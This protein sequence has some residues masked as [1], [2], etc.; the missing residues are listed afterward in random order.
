MT[1]EATAGR[2]TAVPRG[3]A[4]DLAAAGPRT[5]A[6]HLAAAVEARIRAEALGPGDPIGTIEEI[7]AGSGFARAT[8][9]EAV[10]LLADRGVLRIR[11]GRRG[12]LFVADQGPVVRMRRTLLE[13][14]E[15]PSTVAD[16]VELRNE[17]EQLI[18]VGAARRC[19]AAGARTLRDHLATMADAP[20]WDGFVRANWA[21]HEQ[22]AGLC[23]NAMAR[24]VY[25]GTLG[26]LGAASPQ[27][28]G[29]DDPVAYRA[30]RM[31]VHVDLVEAVVGGD[32]AAVRAAVVRHNAPG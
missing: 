25:L 32:E 9:N 13:V 2:A 7:R 6:E 31:Q 30:A 15:D 5:R 21:L 8:V 3:F 29:T 27:L 4:V 28:G 10:R 20:D 26:H 14:R 11:P 16:A 22:L 19:G 18:D 12:G 24:A 17:L 1:D 23:P